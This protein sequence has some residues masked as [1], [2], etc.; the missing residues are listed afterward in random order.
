MAKSFCIISDHLQHNSDSVFTFQTRLLEQI[1]S[2]F[3]NVSTIH[4]FS[5]GA[6]SQYKNYKNMVNLCYHKSDFELDAEWN[7]FAT[8]HGKSPCDGIGGTIKRLVYKTSLQRPSNDQILTPQSMYT[9]CESNIK[10]I[11]FI[12]V[13]SNE[14]IETEK[15]LILRYAKAKKIPGIRSQHRFIP[16]NHNTIKSFA[17]STSSESKLFKIY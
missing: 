6:S 13:H 16:V 7:F 14:V 10:G 8:A 2:E 11:Q 12:Y 5:D 9:F 4:Y 17:I 1:K 15:K 3:P